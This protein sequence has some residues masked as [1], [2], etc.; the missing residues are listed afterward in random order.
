MKKVIKTILWAF[1]GSFVLGCSLY[2][3]SNQRSLAQSEE[4]HDTVKI[5]KQY[6]PF[7]NPNLVKQPLKM[8]TEEQKEFNKK[9]NYVL[10]NAGTSFNNIDLIRGDISELKNL[11]IDRA[12][13]L[14][15]KND[16]LTLAISVLN[17]NQLKAID[18][19]H[20]AELARIRDAQVSK[21]ERELNQAY[22]DAFTM[23]STAGITVFVLLLLGV[24]VL[25]IMVY[26]Q[27]K[28]IKTHFNH[29]L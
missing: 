11:I 2:S 6:R 16:S 4:F 22:R 5:P 10:D 3:C 17:E 12:V 9:L 15:Y 21:K 20:K 19:A 13:S 28:Y 27:K 26:T 8:P 18:F 24:V 23:Y 1:A 29:A 7:A 25:V 14:R